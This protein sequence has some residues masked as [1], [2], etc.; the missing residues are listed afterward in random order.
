MDREAKKIFRYAKISEIS[1]LSTKA[2][3]EA[4]ALL[5]C[6]TKTKQRKL[7]MEVVDAEYQW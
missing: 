3:D 2:Q 4:K 6:Q 7:P 1:Q 5:T